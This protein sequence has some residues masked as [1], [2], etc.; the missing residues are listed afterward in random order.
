MYAHIFNSKFNGRKRRQGWSQVFTDEPVAGGSYK[1][2]WVPKDG[3]SPPTGYEP[4]IESYAFEDLLPLPIETSLTPSGWTIPKRV[5]DAYCM[6][7]EKPGVSVNEHIDMLSRKQLQDDEDRRLRLEAAAEANKDTHAASRAARL[8]PRLLTDSRLHVSPQPRRRALR[9]SAAE[10]PTRRDCDAPS[11]F[12]WLSPSP[13]A[14]ACGPPCTSVAALV[15]FT[16]TRTRPRD[17][18][19]AVWPALTR[20][21]RCKAERKAQHEQAQKQVILLT[22][23]RPRPG[24]NEVDGVERRDGQSTRSTV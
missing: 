12:V 1:E 17:A 8:V 14:V 18:A 10:R 16:L 7:V 21:M 4:W 9:L 22:T 15:L 13:N 3:D 23:M 5:F 24:A 20:W 6:R 2:F 19:L 11:G